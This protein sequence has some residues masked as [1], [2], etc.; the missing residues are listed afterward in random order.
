MEDLR[1]SRAVLAMTRVYLAEEQ[2]DETE[3]VCRVTDCDAEGERLH[4]TLEEGDLTSLSLDAEY[5]CT[6]YPQD[7]YCE[8]TVKERFFDREGARLLF[9]VENGFY[10]NSLN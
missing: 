2:M 9:S 5:R 6:L 3:Y 10:K 1:G 4:L 8:G 7:V